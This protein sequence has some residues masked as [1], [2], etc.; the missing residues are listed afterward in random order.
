MFW[1]LFISL[2]MAEDKEVQ[3]EVVYKQKTEIDFEGVEVEGQMIKPHGSVITDRK[4][5]A[6]NPL[7][8]LR[9]DFQPEMRQLVNDVK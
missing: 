2:V 8:Q 6:F 3:P 4:V 9:T 1:M 5:A 7:I